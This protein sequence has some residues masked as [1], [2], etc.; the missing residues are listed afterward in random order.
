MRSD[1]TFARCEWLQSYD[2]TRS[3]WISCGLL[4]WWPRRQ[5]RMFDNYK[6]TNQPAKGN[7]SVKATTVKLPTFWTHQAAFWFRQA[8]IRF[9]L[10]GITKFYHVFASH[11]VVF[12]SPALADSVFWTTTSTPASLAEARRSETLAAS[13][14]VRP[15]HTTASSP[16][17]TERASTTSYLNP[18]WP[19]A[20]HQK[21][22]AE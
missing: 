22:R 16:C 2:I 21:E 19:K 5:K 11:S 17:T 14:G 8:E 15:S 18:S 20:A 9:A 13:A 6:M 1:A 3:G 4:H 7:F 10:N 12:H